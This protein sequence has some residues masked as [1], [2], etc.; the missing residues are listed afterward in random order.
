M[1]L[2]LRFRQKLHIQ[3]FVE[4]SLAWNERHGQITPCLEHHARFCAH[5]NLLPDSDALVILR[6]ASGC[7]T[8]AAV[9]HGQWQ[10]GRFSC[11]EVA[12]PQPPKP[13]S[14]SRESVLEPGMACGIERCASLHEAAVAA[15]E[16]MD[17]EVCDLHFM[18][19]CRSKFSDF[20][21]Q[22]QNR[23]LL[24]NG[25]PL[26]SQNDWHQARSLSELT[27]IIQDLRAKANSILVSGEALENSQVAQVTAGLDRPP[28]VAPV[29]PGFASTP[30]EGRNQELA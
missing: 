15:V 14:C 26:D 24:H 28:A 18:R 21:F 10:L 25:N 4:T 11:R 29:A 1:S 17:A 7:C 12:L 22:V 6:L 30:P 13:W 5:A 23:V 16:K 27:R 8:S 20:V 9:S 19:G 2:L 3:T